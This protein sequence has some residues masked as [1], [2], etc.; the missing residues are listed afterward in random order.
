[1]KK[2]TLL[3]TG[4]LALVLLMAAGVLGIMG[5]MSGATS[6]SAVG[7]V[8]VGIDFATGD[9]TGTTAGS[10]TTCKVWPPQAATRWTS[11]SRTSPEIPVS[12]QRGTG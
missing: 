7:P 3:K 4:I 11:S 6:T 12:S 2:G 5:L 10:I 9:N 1:M 8:T